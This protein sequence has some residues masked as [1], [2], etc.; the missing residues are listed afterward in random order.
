[1]MNRKL[2]LLWRYAVLL[3]GIGF[4]VAVVIDASR[5]EYNQ[6]AAN[7]LKLIAKPI[8][9]QSVA[10][11]EQTQAQPAI[12]AAPAVIPIDPVMILRAGKRLVTASRNLN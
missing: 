3:S 1:M 5:S 7:V 2:T 12:A 9:G 11:K 4:T 8:P 6:T 10:T